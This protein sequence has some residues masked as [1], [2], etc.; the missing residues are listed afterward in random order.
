LAGECVHEIG[1]RWTSGA[2]Y[3]AFCGVLW[4]I[5]GGTLHFKREN[6]YASL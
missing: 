1:V 5:P 3:K 2:N 6:E 4:L